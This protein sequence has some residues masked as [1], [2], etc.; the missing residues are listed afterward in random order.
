MRTSQFTELAIGLLSLANMT[1]AKAVFAHVVVGVTCSYNQSLWESHISLAQQAGIDA[2]ALNIAPPLADCTATQISNAF[3]AANAL[4][5]QFKLF[6]SF[7]YL[8]GAGP[9]SQADV[10]N[11]LNEYGRD[12]A[13]FTFGADGYPLVSTF[14]GTSNIGDWDDIRKEVGGI[15][16]VPDWTS[17]GTSGF[18]NHL[19][20]V[21]GACKC[22]F[23]PVVRQ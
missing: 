19:D 7:D 12:P 14:E 1:Q 15:Y 20:V 2:F 23:S 8:G 16:F 21:D 10:I 13:H 11:V 4:G 3:A 6:F 22:S 18:A 9:W 17:L 5:A